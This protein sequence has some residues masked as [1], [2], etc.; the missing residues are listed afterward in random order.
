MVPHRAGGGA[1]RRGRGVALAGDP[2]R[3]RRR[4][5]RSWA[6]SRRPWRSC[7]TRTRGWSGEPGAAGVGVVVAASRMR[8]PLE[9]RTL[10]RLAAR[11]A[12]EVAGMVV[13][14]GLSNDERRG[15]TEESRRRSVIARR[16][17]LALVPHAGELLGAEAVGDDAGRG[18]AGAVGARGALGGGSAGARPGGGAGGGAGRCARCRTWHSACTTR[19]ADVPLRTL[20]EAGAQVALGADDPLIFGSPLAG[21]VRECP[22][23]PRLRRPRQF[24]AL[25]RTSWAR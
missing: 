21:P 8:H 3:P 15:A 23:G 13:G 6:A 5:R 14:F 7:S 24:A 10:A 11:H 2:G 25:A 1:G 4:T 16:G 20:V 19:A 12:G 22:G 18:R 9:A 17:G